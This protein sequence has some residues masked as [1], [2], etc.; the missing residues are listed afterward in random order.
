MF[1]APAGTPD[2]IVKRLA[3]ETR[4]RPGA[5]LTEC[6]PATLDPPGPGGWPSRRSPDRLARN[7]TRHH[8]AHDRRRASDA[9]GGPIFA[10]WFAH[11]E[12]RATSHIVKVTKLLSAST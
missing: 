12:P 11:C 2:V 8:A 6:E 7:H 10:W 5:N 3:E 1:L 4:R 9:S